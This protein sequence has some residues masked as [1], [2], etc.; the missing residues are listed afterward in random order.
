[1]RA[2]LVTFAAVCAAATGCD[3]SD[4]G[5]FEQGCRQ[6]TDCGGDGPVVCARNGGCYAASDI[7]A[8]HVNWTV[9]GMP[10]SAASC[11]DQPDLR[12]EFQLGP[13]PSFQDFAYAPVPCAQ[14]KF[15][16]DKLPLDY[17]FV[18]LGQY[19]TQF[20]GATIDAT[21]AEAQIDLK[22]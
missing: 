3:R 1:M 4:D 11:G 6:D 20:F 16:I 17:T 7:R 21:T 8:V 15:T 18:Q 10:A 19:S 13:D 5:S 12:L 2:V 9:N 14:G 22:F